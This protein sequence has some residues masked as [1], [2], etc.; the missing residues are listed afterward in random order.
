MG[1]LDNFMNNHQ[2]KTETEKLLDYFKSHSDVKNRDKFIEILTPIVSGEAVNKLMPEDVLCRVISTI[3]SLE[4]KPENVLKSKVLYDIIVQDDENDVQKELFNRFFELFLK[5]PDMFGDFADFGII[6]NLF[7]NKSLVLSLYRFEEPRYYDYNFKGLRDYVIKSRKYYVDEE[8]YYGAVMQVAKQLA[9]RPFS[10][11]GATQ[12]VNEAL[13]EDKNA[14]G[15]Y[16]IDEENIMDLAEKVNSMLEDIRDVEVASI[17]MK[18][19]Y[20]NLESEINKLTSDAVSDKTAKFIDIYKKALTDIKDIL[21]EMQ[22]KRKNEIEEIKTLGN[23]Y[24]NKIHELLDISPEAEETVKN[25][26]KKG[27]DTI[28]P[29][30]PILDDKISFSE[31][32]R[33]ARQK[34]KET[35]EYYHETFDKILKQVLLNKTVMLVGPS[36]TGK[37]YTIS[38]LARLFNVPVYNLGFIAEEYGTIRGYPDI[39]GNFVKTPF[40]DCLKYGGF[41]SFDEVDNSESKALVE[42]NKVIGAD[43]Y[44][45]YQ[46]PN[47][48]LV[49]PHPNFRIIAAG[50]TWGDGADTL[51]S[52]RE[53]LDAATLNRLK[54]IYYGYDAKLEKN[55]LR[56]YE[57]AYNFAIQ[58]REIVE[59]RGIDK[60]ISTRNFS[61]IKDYLDCGEFSIEEIIEV[62]FTGGMRKDTLAGIYSN[63]AKKLDASNDFFKV[64]EQCAGG[65]KAFIKK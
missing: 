40:Y 21:S 7:T 11:N 57:D 1:L 58:F 23:F 31:R 48:E 10:I 49:K 3:S 42:I 44:V 33:M 36:G 25:G 41:C 51:H 17:E 62:I 35:G 45:P 27:E 22:S 26:L 5:R 65:G 63:L 34:Q 52:T 50:N 28:A 30:N 6:Y 32:L 43:G 2:E 39:N 59:S 15:I 9:K 29:V 60:V 4:K 61:D 55:I 53:Q 20:E 37:S 12:I 19:F 13:L 38:Q 18:S 56:N 64:F 8:A 46:F 54:R 14:A 47:G 24:V 16:D